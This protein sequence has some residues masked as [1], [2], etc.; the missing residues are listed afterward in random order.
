MISASLLSF[1]KYIILSP[2]FNFKLFYYIPRP[3]PVDL[4]FSTDNIKIKPVDAHKHLGVTLSADGKWTKHINNV[5]VKAPRQIAV[6]FRKYLHDLLYMQKTGVRNLIP[7][8]KS[9]SCHFFII[10]LRVIPPII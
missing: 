6:L 9:E 2:Y 4:Y 7:D 3:S 5:V 10:K 8:A 1:S